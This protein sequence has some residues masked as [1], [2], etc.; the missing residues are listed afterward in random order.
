[1]KE[2]EITAEV[3]SGNADRES[4]QS[5]KVIG[6]GGNGQRSESNRNVIISMLRCRGEVEVLG[7]QFCAF[8]S[9]I[10]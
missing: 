2:R 8:C 9:H 7:G 3:F 5:L 10:K 4:E 6:G 1:M